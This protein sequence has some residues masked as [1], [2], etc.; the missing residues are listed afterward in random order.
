MAL[1]AKCGSR[2]A[3]R[4]QE[5]SHD[6]I[7]LLVNVW[8]S[9]VI[10]RPEGRKNLRYMAAGVFGAGIFGCYYDVADSLIAGDRPM[11]LFRDYYAKKGEA[12]SYCGEDKICNSP[13]TSSFSFPQSLQY[14]PKWHLQL[15]EQCFDLL[16]PRRG[17]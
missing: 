7:R 6:G 14:V 13:C 17:Q 4:V 10:F 3:K 2:W 16:D 1:A 15:L 5:S 12:T 11:T 9:T 8:R